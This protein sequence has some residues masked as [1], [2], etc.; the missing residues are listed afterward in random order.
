MEGRVGPGK[1]KV[2]KSTISKFTVIQNCPLPTVTQ[3]TKSTSLMEIST[4]YKTAFGK[5]K[6]TRQ[7]FQE[8]IGDLRLLSKSRLISTYS[9]ELKKKITT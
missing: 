1:E 6:T 7:C 9:L 5:K 3:T 2:F 8:Q 4:N